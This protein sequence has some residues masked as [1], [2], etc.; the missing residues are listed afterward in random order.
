[1]FSNTGHLAETVVRGLALAGFLAA[2]L[3]L[4]T[5]WAVRRKAL[6]P[7]GWWPRLVRRWS[8]PWLKPL[9]R[10]AVRAGGSPQDAPLWLLGI[11]LLGGLFAIGATR[12]LVGAVAG[13]RTMQGA[14]AGAWL[15]L[16]ITT[17][18]SLLM[19]AILIRVIASWL[20]AGRYNRWLRPCY[21]LTDWLIE[22]IRRRLPGFGALDLSPLVAYVL[23][24]VLRSVLL[25][26]L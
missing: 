9:E 17:A 16:A 22:P 20:G 13:L 1:M 10:R 11:V 8:D 4:L 6:Q 26:L 12:W 19:L 15:R 23:V 2:L 24:L 5:H 3:I 21:W 7:F 14:P 18:T 25:G